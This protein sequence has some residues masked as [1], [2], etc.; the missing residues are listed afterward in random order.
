[1]KPTTAN[2]LILALALV[3][4]VALMNLVQ[5]LQVLSFQEVVIETPIPSIPR[6]GF[7]PFLLVLGMGLAG[8][9][10]FIVAFLKYRP[11]GGRFPF[12]ELIPIVLAVV[13]LLALA[14][15]V[16][17]T[18]PDEVAADGEEETGTGG[19]AGAEEPGLGILERLQALR[20]VPGMLPLIFAFLAVVAIY[21]LIAN[22]R[23]RRAFSDEGLARRKRALKTELTQALEEHLYKIRIAEDVRSAILGSYRDMVNLFHS[24]G[25]RSSRHLTAREVETLARESLGLSGEASEELRRLFEVARYSPHPLSDGHRDAAIESLRRVTRELGA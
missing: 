6:L 5:N 16:E 13:V 15:L 19:E 3:V 11:R 20:L 22:F 17:P 23:V 1:M 4:S 12:G 14:I 24:Y 25:L 10:I 2:L 18:P 8:G 9:A 7:D 21:L